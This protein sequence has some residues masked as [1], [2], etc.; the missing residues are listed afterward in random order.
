MNEGKE[1]EVTVRI[2]VLA[3]GSLDK[4]M[5]LQSSGDSRLDKVTVNSITQGWRFKPV[6]K[7]YYID[8][9]FVFNL[10]SGVTVKFVKS[11]TGK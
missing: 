3:S 2:L 6:T 5:L 8:L 7:D 9:I 1:G 11:E 10:Q 4:V